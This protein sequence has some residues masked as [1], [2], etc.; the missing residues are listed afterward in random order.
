[1]SGTVFGMNL[2]RSFGQ[3]SRHASRQASRHAPAIARRAAILIGL[4]CLAFT[5]LEPARAAGPSLVVDARTGVVLHAERATEPWYPASVTKL[6]TAYIAL[7]HVR[8]GRL[9]F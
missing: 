2:A 6:L 8:H 5:S 3:A 9:A 7:D 4:A 1:M